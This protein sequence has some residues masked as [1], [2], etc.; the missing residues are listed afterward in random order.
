MK[1][2]DSRSLLDELAADQAGPVRACKWEQLLATLDPE[3]ADQLRAAVADERFTLSSIGRALERRN[4]DVHRGLL[5]RHRNRRC[6]RC[7]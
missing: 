5:E 7:R 1:A 2:E 3:L 4:L 6:T